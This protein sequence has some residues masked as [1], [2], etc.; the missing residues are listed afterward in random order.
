MILARLHGIELDIIPVEVG[1]PEGYT[2]GDNPLGKIPALE[3]QPG[4]WLFDSPVI[5]EWLDAKGDVPLLPDERHPRTIQQWQ[6]ALGDG[7]SDATYNLRY[8][9]AR[10]QELHWPQ[11]IARHE[12][13]LRSAVETL[14]SISDWLGTDWTY[15]NL[16]VVCGLDYMQFR[17]GH[18]DW[19][20]NA[21]KLA[22]WFANFASKPEY[23]DTYA[24]S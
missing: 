20:A 18:L 2:S 19:R 11:M 21:P 3:W 15:G 10:P 24:Y 23:M 16:A 1:N 4:Q 6:H 22:D 13:A 9:M 12:A 7:V 5:C 14:E 17:A 8:E